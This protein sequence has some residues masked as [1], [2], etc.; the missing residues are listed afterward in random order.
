MTQVFAK[1][2]RKDQSTFDAAFLESLLNILITANRIFDQKIR[3]RFYAIDDLPGVV[4]MRVVQYADTDV[5]YFAAQC[6]SKQ[7]YL[8]DRQ[9]EKNQQRSLIA[10]H[11]IKLFSDESE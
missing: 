4:V 9:T 10:E 11:M 1:I 7:D 3:A 6:K 8:H 5:F 2:C